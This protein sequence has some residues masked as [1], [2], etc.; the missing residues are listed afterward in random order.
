M[1]NVDELHSIDLANVVVSRSGTLGDQET[2]SRQT[3]VGGMSSGVFPIEIP[4]P[5][6]SLPVGPSPIV[7]DPLRGFL[8]CVMNSSQE[9]HTR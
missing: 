1:S 3:R 6:T 2:G 7:I 9:P 5:V 8:R 4:S